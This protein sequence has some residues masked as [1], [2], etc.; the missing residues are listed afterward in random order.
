MRFLQLALAS[1]LAFTP[2]TANAQSDSEMMFKN[3]SRLTQTEG[4]DIY[5][6]ICAGCH[7]PEGEGA[8]GAGKYPA[9]ANNETLEAAGYPI[10]VVIHGQ[11]AMPPLGRVLNDEQIAAVVEYIRTNL[12]NNYT[13]PVTVEEVTESR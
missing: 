4:K 9:L 1:A 13:D 10:Y 11:R 12:G 6:A 5:G 8:V 2:A 7:M 3:P